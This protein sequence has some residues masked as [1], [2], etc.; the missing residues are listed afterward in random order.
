MRPV[1]NDT[2]TRNQELR[3]FFFATTC[4]S[5][6]TDQA[7]SVY[8]KNI[9]LWANWKDKDT[10]T[11][12]NAYT[13]GDG[14]VK[15]TGVELTKVRL[16]CELMPN[17][18]QYPPTVE[19]NEPMNWPVYLDWLLYVGKETNVL[20]PVEFAAPSP[21]FANL[22]NN[23][24]CAPLLQ[25]ASTPVDAIL[26]WGTEFLQPPL[27]TS[28]TLVYQ[29]SIYQMPV[30]LTD[31]TGGGTLTKIQNANITYAPAAL[32][33]A[34]TFG[35]IKFEKEFNI[36][37]RI[38]NRQE[39]RLVCRLISDLDSP[40]WLPNEGWIDYEGKYARSSI[41]GRGIIQVDYRT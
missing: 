30:A 22:D 15:P 41:R 4:V 2:Y 25:S 37:Q 6:D 33:G 34:K 14:T 40:D 32:A 17:M 7:K 18:I 24:W 19:D 10:A 16:D 31:G 20:G 29:D 5:P 36:P 38:E 12:A 28:H 35:K 11:F 1:R 8:Q 26:G 39:I 27:A 23:I 3:Q 21:S 9:L 13:D